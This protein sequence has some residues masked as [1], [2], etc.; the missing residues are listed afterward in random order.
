MPGRSGSARLVVA[1]QRAQE[2]V[3]VLRRLGEAGIGQQRLLVVQDARR[4]AVRNAEQLAL[5]AR[6][7]ADR[8]QEVV[9]V[10]I[11]M[12]GRR[13]WPAASR[14]P[15]CAARASRRYGA[16]HWMMSMPT[17]PEFSSAFSRA[18]SASIGSS[19][20]STLMPVCFLERRCDFLDQA[21]VPRAVVADE[22]QLV[23]LAG[24]ASAKLGI[25]SGGGRRPADAAPDHRPIPARRRLRCQSAATS[26]SACFAVFWPSSVCEMAGAQLQLQRVPDRMGRASGRR[27]RSPARR[28]AASRS[29][30]PSRDR[31]APSRA[32]ARCRGSSSAACQSLAAA[33]AMN[34]S[35]QSLF[36]VYFGTPRK[37]PST[38]VRPCDLVGAGRA[39][40]P[41]PT[42]RRSS[43]A[44]DR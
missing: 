13:C 14:G 43:T 38:Q 4:H 11:G 3:P 10:E 39:P 25:A 29:S 33:I 8:R 15:P 20:K 27:S 41:R 23:G 34:S 7:V 32:A 2:L 30:R 16:V 36:L 26:S 9:P 1:M 24:C 35:D 37:W 19:V 28:P 22:H 5:I 21:P 18:L 12:P 44:S 40:C 42:C 17:E 6:H 31:A